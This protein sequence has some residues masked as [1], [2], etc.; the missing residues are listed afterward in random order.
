M[1]EKKQR[2]APSPF[3]SASRLSLG[4]REEP[5]QSANLCSPER[6]NRRRGASATLLIVVFAIVELM[7]FGYGYSCLLDGNRFPSSYAG[8][9]L[10]QGTPWIEATNEPN[11]WHAWVKSHYPER[12]VKPTIEGSQCLIHEVLKSRGAPCCVIE[13]SPRGYIF[14]TLFQDASP[15]R[16]G[17]LCSATTW[18]RWFW[19]LNDSSETLLHVW[20]IYVFQI[21]LL[22]AL[23]VVGDV[24]WCR[25]RAGGDD[26]DAS[27]RRRALLI[28]GPGFLALG[29]IQFCLYETPTVSLLAIFRWYQDPESWSIFGQG[30]GWIVGLP[31]MLV[32][33]FAHLLWV[34][35]GWLASWAVLTLGAIGVLIP[36]PQILIG[37]LFPA[38]PR[39]RNSESRILV[40]LQFA[41]G[42]FLLLTHA[43]WQSLYITLVCG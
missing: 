5:R 31:L 21:G 27:D 8:A 38:P 19:S 2:W 35:L 10:Q 17:S 1:F 29:L 34:N 7:A 14:R 41:A 15:T 37:G 22:A 18:W 20:L 42:P 12:D 26:A 16:H 3:P 39:L 13:N 28:L 30:Y 43:L 40:L 23:A 32:L 6:P 9:W 4:Q 25:I 33:W 24:L 11:Y 36:A